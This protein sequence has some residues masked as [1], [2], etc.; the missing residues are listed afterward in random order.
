MK[1]SKILLTTLATTIACA[2]PAPS[3]TDQ[4]KVLPPAE[5]P[6]LALAEERQA[7]E[8]ALVDYLR[9]LAPGESPL[10]EESHAIFRDE[11][12]PGL[13]RLIADA[14]DFF[15][16]SQGDHEVF[17]WHLYRKTQASLSFHCVFPLALYPEGIPQEVQDKMRESNDA[18][19]L[20]GIE[21][22]VYKFEPFIAE[23]SPS[24]REHLENAFELMSVEDTSA[25]ELCQ[26]TRHLWH[27]DEFQPFTELVSPEPPTYVDA[28]EALLARLNP[29]T[30][31]L[32]DEEALASPGVVGAQMLTEEALEAMRESDEV[33]LI[34]LGGAGCNPS[35]NFARWA[36]PVF[37]EH[38]LIDRTFVVSFRHPSTAILQSIYGAR[39]ATPTLI[40]LK[41]GVPVD[42][43]IGGFQ[44]D[45][46]DR[47]APN[48]LIQNGFIDGEVTVERDFRERSADEIRL[49]LKRSGGVSVF[50]NLSGADLQNI[51]H[52]HAS[53]SG[54]ILRDVDLRGAALPN[55]NFA[56]ADLTGANLEGADV[57]GALWHQTT[58]PDGSMSEEHGESCEGTW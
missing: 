52:P 35:V 22:H 8:D 16:A 29:K 46:I 14:E 38:G 24:W 50:T 28:P 55:V 2:T 57:E 54:S 44:E 15:V 20:S 45:T 58:C 47:Y 23:A 43:R 12:G 6:T 7:F 4:D 34:F 48:F 5:P 26:A 39:L 21:R 49:W 11:K 1:N 19:M 18:S 17:G 3:S 37:E 30:P 41:R 32:T 13:R 33:F 36:A 25:A 51:A 31:P 53:F 42:Y 27:P 9:V 10:E 56:H 40:A